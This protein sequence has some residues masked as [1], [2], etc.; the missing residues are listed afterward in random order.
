MWVFCQLESISLAGCPVLLH[1]CGT[2]PCRAIISV[3]ISTSCITYIKSLQGFRHETAD[4]KAC[5]LAAEERVLWYS[6]EF[7]DWDIAN[8]SIPREVC[9]RHPHFIPLS[10]GCLLH[11][12][13]LPNWRYLLSI[14]A[15]SCACTA[16]CFWHHKGDCGALSPSLVLSLHLCCTADHWQRWGVRQCMGKAVTFSVTYRHPGGNSWPPSKPYSPGPGFRVQ[17]DFLSVIPGPQ[18]DCSTVQDDILMYGGRGGR[19][20]RPDLVSDGWRI[21]SEFLKQDKGLVSPRGLGG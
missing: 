4:L 12:P 20:T 1:L 2:R 3:R 6:S 11:N 17:G 18:M 8:G 19:E 10:A 15:L 5:T 7:R 9:P 16:Q 21:A 14:T 13:T